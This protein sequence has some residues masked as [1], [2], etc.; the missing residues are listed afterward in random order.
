MAILHFTNWPWHNKSYLWHEDQ[1]EC[2]GG[3]EYDEYGDDDEG[4]GLFILQHEGDRHAEDA[5]DGNVVNRH[6]DVLGVVERRNLNLTRLPSQ[7]R[8]K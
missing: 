2:Q 8:T 6:A 7:E 1:A 5:H 3:A 4:G